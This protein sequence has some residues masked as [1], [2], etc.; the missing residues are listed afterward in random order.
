[1]VVVAQKWNFETYIVHHFGSV[2][3]DVQLLQG[4]QI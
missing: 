2:F 3:R 1:M 4:K